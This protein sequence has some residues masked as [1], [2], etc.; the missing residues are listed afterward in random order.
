MISFL[1]LWI[2]CPVVIAC[3]TERGKARLVSG[4]DQPYFPG[5]Q[6]M[7]CRLGRAAQ[8][9]NRIGETGHE[10]KGR[11]R[12]DVAEALSRDVTLALVRCRCW[13]LRSPCL[14][15]TP[16]RPFVTFVA[17]LLHYCLFF[18]YTPPS[19]SSR[20]IRTTSFVEPASASSL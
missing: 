14:A 15:G 6:Q 10:A 4:S 5:L 7:A 8:M 2:C 16:D 3:S 11:I 13:S 12:S 1:P 20:H 19:I 9:K 18:G 17:H